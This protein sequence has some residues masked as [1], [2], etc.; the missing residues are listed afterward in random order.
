MKIEKIN[1]LT[2]LIVL[3]LTTLSMNAQSIRRDDFKFKSNYWY[4]RAD[5][6]QSVPTVDNGLLHLKLENAVDTGYCNT[7]IYDPYI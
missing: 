7:E 6:N 5:G 2:L 4:W 3:L 1:Y